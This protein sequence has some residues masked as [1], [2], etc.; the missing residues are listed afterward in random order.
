MEQVHSA[1]AAVVGAGLAFSCPRL[2][3]VNATTAKGRQ[4]QA[5]P[6]QPRRLGG[7]GVNF[8]VSQENLHKNQYL[9]SIFH[10]SFIG[11]LE[12]LGSTSLPTFEHFPGVYPE[13]PIFHDMS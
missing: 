2:L 3:R 6:F 4:G 8:G 9:S 10:L 12:D 5:R 1:E 13:Y 7:L 11:G